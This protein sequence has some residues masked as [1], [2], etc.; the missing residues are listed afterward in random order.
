MIKYFFILLFFLNTSQ[1]SD[2]INIT[3]LGTGTPR[4]NIDKLGPSILLKYQNDEILFDVG[5]GTTLRLEQLNNN[6]TKIDNIFI[7]HMHFDH[8]V[9]LADFWL[10]SSLWQKKTNT[11]IYGPK[12]IKKFCSQIKKLYEK[13]LEYRY[14]NNSYNQL[15]CLYHQDVKKYN[16]LLSITPFKNDHGH[17][18]NSYGFKINFGNKKIIYS[19]DTTYSKNV[20]NNSKNADIL[21]HEVISVS[22]KIYD[23]NKKLRKVVNSHTNV[24]QLIQILNICK[25]KLTILNHALLFGVNEQSVLARIAKEYNGKVIF[26]KDFMSVDLGEEINIFNTGK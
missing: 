18:D 7:S 25:P 17:V 14:E 6:Y 4:P 21:I 9:G 10:T 3:F 2:I 15:N 13:D 23:N 12:G 24:S 26:A 1:A 16:N 19:G 22:K 20:I 5:R 11:N 8:I